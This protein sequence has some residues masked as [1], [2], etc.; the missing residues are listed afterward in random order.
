MQHLVFVPII[1]AILIIP[2]FLMGA[3]MFSGVC[4]ATL[5]IGACIGEMVG[6]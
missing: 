5:V 2:A 4:M 6:D 1:A 3:F